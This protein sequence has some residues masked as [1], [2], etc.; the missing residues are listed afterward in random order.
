MYDKTII[1]KAQKEKYTNI[2][3]EIINNKNISLPALGFMVYILSK[4]N[5]WKILPE[6]LSKIM[7]KKENSKASYRYILE[8]INELEN[9]GYI[10]KHKNGNGTMTYLVYEEPKNINPNA[11]IP[12]EEKNQEDNNTPDV[13]NQHKEQKSQNVD[14][15]NAE[16]PHEEKTQKDN[17]TPD[18]ENQH[19]EQKSQNVDNPNAEI[20]HEEIPH[21]EIPHHIINT[22][23]K[24]NTKEKRNALDQT[25]SLACSFDS[26]WNIYPLKKKKQDAI[27]KFT[28]LT[29]RELEILMPATYAYLKY[30]EESGEKLAYPSTYLHQK[31]FLDYEDEIKNSNAQILEPNEGAEISK[32]ESLST[33]ILD[34]LIMYEEFS[35]EE[36][37][38]ANKLPYEKFRT[39]EGAEIFEE[40]EIEA[41]NELGASLED[42][43]EMNYKENEILRIIKGWV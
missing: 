7:F 16:I 33:K 6:H 3:N 43:K 14:N 10:V 1:R 13:E 12:H 24:I 25:Y 9:L 31:V 40:Y 8:I 41:L 28:K 23:L 42:F 18:V 5:N 27:A 26:W 38:K 34:L 17:N 37:E 29:K 36:K 30:K 20:P 15:P 11:E 32:A 4:P 22:N 39:N 21:E 19:K 35:N 2:D